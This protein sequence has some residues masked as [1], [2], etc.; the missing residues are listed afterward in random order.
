MLA[1]TL[2]INGRQLGRIGIHNT[3][4]D[5]DDGTV[6]D[7]YDISD[8]EPGDSITD[9]PYLGTVVHERSDGA[10]ELARIVLDDVDESHFE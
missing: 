10:A 2:D 8:I 6:Y 1:V 7:Y 4:I 3:G 9:Q 5:H